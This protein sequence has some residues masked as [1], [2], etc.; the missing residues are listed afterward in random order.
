LLLWE[1]NYKSDISLDDAGALAAA[2]ISIA[3][4]DKE[5]SQ[6]I[7]MSQILSDTEIMPEEQVKKYSKIASE[8]YPSDKR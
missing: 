2:S 4:E 8:K 7:I 5:V 6:N 3:S 1:K